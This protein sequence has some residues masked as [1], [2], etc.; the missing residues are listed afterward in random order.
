MRSIKISTTHLTVAQNKNVKKKMN[1]WI[2]LS[3]FKAVQNLCDKIGVLLVEQKS[4]TFI[5]QCEKYSQR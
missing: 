2:K 1:G 4:A 3:E 5:F